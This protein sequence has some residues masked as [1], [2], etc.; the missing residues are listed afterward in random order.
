ML[1]STHLKLCHNQIII[2]MNDLMV[3]IKKTSG[4]LQETTSAVS[5][6]VPYVTDREN[7]RLKY[8]LYY[9]EAISG[10]FFHSIAFPV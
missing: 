10:H 1:E 7:S 4:F 6:H 3:F 9:L 5:H 2:I 8:C